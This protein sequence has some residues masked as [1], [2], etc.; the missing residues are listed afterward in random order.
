MRLLKFRVNF[1][2]EWDAQAGGVK[3]KGKQFRSRVG[4]LRAEG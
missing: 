1:H 3:Q 2:V 4:G